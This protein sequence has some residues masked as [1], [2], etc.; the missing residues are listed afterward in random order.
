MTINW[1]SIVH[2]PVQH[3]KTKYIKID[4]HFIKE[5]LDNG[6][7]CTSYMSIN[8]QLED[9]LTKSVSNSIFLFLYVLQQAKKIHCDFLKKIR[10]LREIE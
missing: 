7:I 4:K 2:N 6:L 1:L 9:V 5:K 10:K 8:P 3:D